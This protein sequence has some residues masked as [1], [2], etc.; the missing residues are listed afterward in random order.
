MSVLTDLFG[1]FSVQLPL[2]LSFKFVYTYTLNNMN[3]NIQLKGDV[4]LEQV[5]FQ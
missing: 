1:S 4:L 3:T 2:F 5:T